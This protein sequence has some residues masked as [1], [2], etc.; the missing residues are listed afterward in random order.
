MP[1]GVTSTGFEAKTL[2][3]ILTEMRSTIWNA[4]SKT[5][6]LSETSLLGQF[7][8]VTASKLRELWEA[9]QASYAAK[10]PD[11][12]TGQALTNLCKLTGTRR[13]AA[14]ATTAEVDITALAAGTYAIGA[15]VLHKLDDED[16]RFF[17]SEEIVHAGGAISGVVFEAEEVGPILL[18][19]DTLTQIANPIVGFSGVT[20]PEA[21]VTGKDEETDTELRI[22]RE[23]ELARRG[24]STVD[25]IRA[26]ILEVDGVTSCLVVENVTDVVDAN[27]TAAHGVQ[28]IVRGGVDQEVADALWFAKAAGIETTGSEVETVTDSQ[29]NTH[30]TRFNRAVAL[31]WYGLLRINVDQ[32]IAPDDDGVIALD[33]GERLEAAGIVPELPTGQDVRRAEIIRVLMTCPYVVDVTEVSIDTSAIAGPMT[34]NVVVDFNEYAT[35]TALALYTTRVPGTP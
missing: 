8:G 29:G 4:V 35:N 22:R 2:T 20:N 7:L 18:P 1:Y 31:G 19:A 10:D 24:S 14:Y 15:L 16:A 17:N 23:L 6:N 30:T 12:A 33:I 21:G 25:A 3:T 28:A 5:L 9:A 27:G 11:Q 13:R 26:D 34:S 32:T